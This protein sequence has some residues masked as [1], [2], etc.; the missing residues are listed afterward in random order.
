MAVT[1][2]WLESKLILGQRKLTLCVDLVGFLPVPG[3][4]TGDC[5]AE[6][7]LFIIDCLDLANKVISC[8]CKNGKDCDSFLCMCHLRRYP[9]LEQ[10]GRQSIWL[11]VHWADGT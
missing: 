7:F 2:H 6:E 11:C 3:S 9:V 4:H 1:A 8:A 10:A 5:L